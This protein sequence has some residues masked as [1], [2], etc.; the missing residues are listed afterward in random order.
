MPSTLERWPFSNGSD[1]E[2][3][4]TRT[5]Q[6]CFSTP[7]ETV[8]CP[9]LVSPAYNVST[10]YNAFGDLVHA[11]LASAERLSEKNTVQ[12]ILYSHH[13]SIEASFNCSRFITLL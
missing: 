13:S 8:R 7:T 11:I 5:L 3:I 2:S 4:E 9:L 6:Q 10:A 12:K 1:L